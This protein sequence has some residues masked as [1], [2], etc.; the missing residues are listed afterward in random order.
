MNAQNKYNTAFQLR[1]KTGSS[2]LSFSYRSNMIGK[3]CRSNSSLT[4]ITGTLSSSGFL[5]LKQT[6]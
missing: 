4:G 1:N 2:V 3:N 6:D 5:T